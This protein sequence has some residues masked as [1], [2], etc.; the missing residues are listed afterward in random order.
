[1]QENLPII[2]NDN[3]TLYERKTA[4]KKYLVTLLLLASLLLLTACGNRSLFDTTYTFTR[5]MIAMPDGSVVTG[6][7]ESWRDYDDGDQLQVTINGV[8]YL[9]HASNVVLMN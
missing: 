2:T 1:V 7:V 5:A 8:T 9:T 3:I 6:T 4:V